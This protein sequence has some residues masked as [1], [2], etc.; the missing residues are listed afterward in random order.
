MMI[1]NLLLNVLF[2]L[3]NIFISIFIYMI[4]FIIGVNYYFIVYNRINKHEINGLLLNQILINFNNQVYSF[5]FYGLLVIECLFLLV[6]S[7]VYV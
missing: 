3:Y 5:I 2:I 1:D 4:I 7:Y 6:L